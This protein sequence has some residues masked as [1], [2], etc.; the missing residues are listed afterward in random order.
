MTSPDP[1]RPSWLTRIVTSQLVTKLL[2]LVAIGSGLATCGVLLQGLSSDRVQSE[3]LQA[4]AAQLLEA[5]ARQEVLL[6]QLTGLANSP[7]VTRW[8]DARGAEWVVTTSAEPGE[9][10]AEVRLRHDA[11]VEE[12]MDTHKPAPE[13]PR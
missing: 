11:D 5:T 8:H 9:T 13:S 7:R 3:R 6:R 2:L 1:A 4:T 10:L 12:S